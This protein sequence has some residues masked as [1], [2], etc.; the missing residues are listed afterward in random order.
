VKQP[1]KS[2]LTSWVRY[3]L[4]GFLAFV[5]IAEVLTDL[6]SGSLLPGFVWSCP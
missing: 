2:E 1:A 5:L 6:Q 4:Y 3:Y